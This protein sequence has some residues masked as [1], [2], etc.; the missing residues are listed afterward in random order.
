MRLMGIERDQSACNYYRILLPLYTLDK[1]NLAEVNIIKEEQLGGENAINTALLSDVIVFQRPATESWFNFI[2]TC[3][4]YGKIIVSDY[5]DDPLNTSP[6]N[7]SYQYTGTEEVRWSWPD[8]TT[9]AL[10]SEGMVSA[11]GNKIFDI[12]RNIR[13]RDMFRL[14]FKKSDMITCTTDN[15]REAFLKINPNVSVLPNCIDKDFFPEPLEVV[16]RDVR[17][18]WQGGASHYE[19]L[20]MVKDAIVQVLRENPNVKFIYFGDMRF[21]GLFKDAPPSQIEWHSWVSHSSYPYKLALMNWDIGLCPL[22]DNEFNRNKSA[23]KW[24]EY[25]MVNCATIASNIPP[26]ATVITPTQDGLLVPDDKWKDAMEE[27]IKDSVL[28]N[29]LA[30]NA[31]E[32]VLSNHNIE[33]KA[34]LWLEAYKKLLKPELART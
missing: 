7:P 26:Y 4:K 15:L 30:S 25:S 19:D 31:K 28:R 13:N 11:K 2:K 8:G 14:N 3:R 16:K 10:W 9:E 34:H 20:Y 29:K 32:N 33:T 5:D 18:G 12:E 27:L 23:I 24:M 1:L 22:V 6:L 21:Q 17:I